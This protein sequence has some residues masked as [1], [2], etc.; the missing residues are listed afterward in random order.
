MV[1]D[2]Y[3]AAASPITRLLKNGLSIND[4]NR[5]TVEKELWPTLKH[6]RACLATLPLLV[7]LADMQ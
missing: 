6:V 7:M 2:D 5:E 1:R 3:Y 4:S